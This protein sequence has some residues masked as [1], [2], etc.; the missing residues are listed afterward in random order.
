MSNS[1]APQ[2]EI[3]QTIS[4]SVT[5]LRDLIRTVS[6]DNVQSQ[7]ILAAERL[8]SNIRFSSKLY[9]GAI[10]AL[11]GNE[12]VRKENLKVLFGLGSGG[13]VKI[14]RKSTSLIAFFLFCCAWKPCLTNSEIA[15][16]AFSMS[17]ESRILKE[18]PVASFQL[19]DLIQSFSGHSEAL[20]PVDLMNELAVEINQH[21]PGNPHFYHRTE[22]ETLG[23][24]LVRIFDLLID[25]SVA[26]ITLSGQQGGTWL[27]TFFCFLIPEDTIFSI[28]SKIVRGSNKSAKLRLELETGLEIGTGSWMVKEW[29]NEQP[30]SFVIKIEGRYEAQCSYI[31]LNLTKS[32]SSQYFGPEFDEP[33]RRS[34]ISTIGEL[35]GALIVLLLEFG[36]ICEVETCCERSARKTCKMVSLM[37]VF[38]D[39]WVKECDSIIKRYGW[40][41]STA[42]GQ[43]QM[44]GM[45]RPQ[46]EGLA[47]RHQEYRGD[48][49][50][51]KGR[52]TSF[53][54]K[55][56]S[57][58]LVNDEDWRTSGLVLDT[59]LYI[60]VD[61]VI[62]AT[63]QLE[64]GT[65]RIAPLTQKAF[66]FTDTCCDSLLSLHGM[67][68]Q[69]YHKHA[70]AQILPGNPPF[71]D[72]DIVISSNGY[73]AG[74]NSLWEMSMRKDDAL[75]IRI[76]RGVI[77]RDEIS[78]KSIREGKGYPIENLERQAVSHLEPFQADDYLG[79]EPRC[80]EE[81]LTIEMTVA[82]VGTRLH[83]RT[84]LLC[85]G[86][87]INPLSW[88][89]SIHGLVFAK[90]VTNEFG[91]TV[92]QEEEL[93]RRHKSTLSLVYWQ[94]C[95][96]W[97]RGDSE[98]KTILKTFENP[99]LRFFSCG[100]LY[101]QRQMRMRTKCFTLVVRHSGQ[102]LSSVLA[103]EDSETAWAVV[104]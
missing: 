73:V 82:V 70:L 41:D 68:I 65:R 103:G 13:T 57:E 53:I 84:Y 29:R 7:A 27:A 85:D 69:E 81:N 63:S 49:Y 16:L 64:S 62:T 47:G 50:N 35:A 54:A 77:K 58:K 78:Y 45:L 83:L 91:Y 96:I 86:E 97:G 39:H 34:A 42:S 61:A 18:F 44:V 21:A 23:K 101:Q 76:V 48:F 33:T 4:T 2:W 88:R 36:S 15:D 72:S 98:K 71:D 3:G 92:R 104:C 93:A 24:I 11:N 99:F 10:R 19:C 14:I 52:I 67:K 46:F 12:S 94:S 30:T 40:D 66:R 89:D 20:I 31:P 55:R 59:A 6:V 28:D 60:A 80:E 90:H 100:L 75:T 9:S 26:A 56:L 5:G 74:I 22:I 17:T 51:F 43:K 38:P 102:L 37:E 8:G 79:L 1:I 32:Y 87:H 95:H 25:E